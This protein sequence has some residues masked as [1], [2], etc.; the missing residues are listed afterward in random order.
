MRIIG[1][2]TIE[3]FRSAQGADR[4]GDKEFAS[5]GTID[6][7]LFQWASANS[8]A[9]RYHDGKGFEESFRLSAVVFCP[10]DAAIQLQPRDRIIFR[11]TLCQV[12]G[13]QEWN[14]NNPVTG[15]KYTHYMM[16]VELVS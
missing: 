16:Q 12:V 15:S 4:F 2:D 11:G 5:V 13:D 1:G 7:V 3:V 10:R 14:N 9:L 6:R 8:S